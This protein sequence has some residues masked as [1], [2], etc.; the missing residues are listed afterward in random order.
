MSGAMP[1]DSGEAQRLRV[2]IKY[3]EILW[4]PNPNIVDTLYFI[5]ITTLLANIPFLVVVSDII[6]TYCIITI[7]RLIYY[8]L[9][10]I[11]N[12]I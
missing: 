8:K 11:I 7:S 1:R 3:Y 10:S 2:D 6:L 4:S 12:D 9:K 5:Y